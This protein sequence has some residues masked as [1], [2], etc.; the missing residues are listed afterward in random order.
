MIKNTILNLHHSTSKKYK[1]TLLLLS[2]IGLSSL[3]TISVYFQQLVLY[4]I[5]ASFVVLTFGGGAFYEI[6]K[7]QN[8]RKNEKIPTIYSMVAIICTI[9]MSFSFSIMFYGAFN[10]VQGLSQGLYQPGVK[11]LAITGG[12]ILF[13]YLVI[14]YG[15]TLR[16]LF[17]K[18]TK[19]KYVQGA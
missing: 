16:S 3:I 1:A 4:V 17:R 5:I 14:L 15:I 7:A 19:A 12:M 2:V 10:I 11:I 8:N 13:S 6:L 18:K 9:L